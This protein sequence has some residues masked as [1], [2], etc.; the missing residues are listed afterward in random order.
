MAA[1]LST[2]LNN[3][4]GENEADVISRNHHILFQ[5]A[6]CMRRG[7]K[8]KHDQDELKSTI[9]SLTCKQRRTVRLL[10]SN[11]KLPLGTVHYLLKPRPPPKAASLHGGIILKRHTSKLKPT[12]KEANKL[13]RFMFC[14]NEVNKATDGLQGNVKF[15][16]Q[17]DKVHVDEKW[18]WICKD[19][20]KYLLVDEEEGDVL[21]GSG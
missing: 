7:G 20:E 15:Q 1:S 13:T 2:L 4:P 11:L 3:H 9:A 6:H 18:F 5:P 16:D 14:A 10:A 8:F 17:M 12:L 21:H 19:G